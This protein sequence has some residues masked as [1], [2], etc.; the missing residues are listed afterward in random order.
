MVRLSKSSGVT[1]SNSIALI[2]PDRVVCVSRPGRR[3]CRRSHSGRSTLTPL[4]FAGPFTLA[5]MRGWYAAGYLPPNHRQAPSILPGNPHKCTRPHQA[6][7]LLFAPWPSQHRAF[8]AS[9]LLLALKVPTLRRVK[10]DDEFEYTELRSVS[11]L[12]WCTCLRSQ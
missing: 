11:A 7:A 2:H 5:H 8:S 1:H 12:G 3:T 6:T 4:W 9:P 10:R